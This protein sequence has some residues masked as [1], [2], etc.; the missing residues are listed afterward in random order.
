MQ[1]AYIDIFQ[2]IPASSGN[3]WYTLQ[4]ARDLQDIGVVTLYSTQQ[5]DGKRGYVPTDSSVRQRFLKTSVKWDKIWPRLNQL[6]PEM[7]FDSSVAFI[8][9]TSPGMSRRKTKPYSCW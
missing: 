8:A 9:I 2:H 5:R 4:L 3:N 1:I 7:L 6:K